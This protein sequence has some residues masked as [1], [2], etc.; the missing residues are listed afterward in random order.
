LGERF[1]TEA[2]KIETKAEDAIDILNQ[3]FA[4]AVQPM[5]HRKRHLFT[6]LVLVSVTLG[7]CGQVRKI[8]AEGGG[9]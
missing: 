3:F 1:V 9:C 4:R 7:I 5:A 2:R 6:F 8:E